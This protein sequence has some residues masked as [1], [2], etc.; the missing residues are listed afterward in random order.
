M[1]VTPRFPEVADEAPHV[2]PQFH[3]DAGGRLV[4][5]EDLRFMGK[6]LAIITRRFMPPESVMIL[7]SRFSQ[8]ER[9]FSS[10]SMRAGSGFLPNRPRLRRTVAVTVSKASVVS[11]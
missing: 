11:S 9:S 6:R 8:R 5:E 2:P 1:M 7:A 3:I 10:R 4:E